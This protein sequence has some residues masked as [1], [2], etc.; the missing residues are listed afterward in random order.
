MVE[1]PI[2]QIKKES[3]LEFELLTPENIFNIIQW[4]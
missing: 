4:H 2:D 1:E 3:E